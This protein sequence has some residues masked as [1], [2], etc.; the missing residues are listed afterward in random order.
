M[1]ALTIVL[2]ADLLSIRREA[3][4]Q[5]RAAGSHQVLLPAAPARVRRVPRDAVAAGAVE[6]A[7]LGRALRGA[8]CVVLAGVV[9]CVGEGAA[10][11]L[12]AG[13]DVVLVRLVAGAV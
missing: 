13:Q 2:T 3:V 10:V 6:V 4:E 9:R 1:N 5:A 12:R 8:A 7:D 11:R